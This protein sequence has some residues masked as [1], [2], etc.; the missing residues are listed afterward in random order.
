MKNAFIVR[1]ISQISLR[2]VRR[3]LCRLSRHLLMWIE[4]THVI[5]N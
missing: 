1:S 2:M 4:L 5:D 3:P